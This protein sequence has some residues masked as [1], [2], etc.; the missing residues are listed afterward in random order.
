MMLDI[1]SEEAP[2]EAGIFG[3]YRE[4]KGGGAPVSQGWIWSLGTERNKE[5]EG[6][7]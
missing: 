2:M 4:S 1:P 3:K 5:R 6:G 7:F